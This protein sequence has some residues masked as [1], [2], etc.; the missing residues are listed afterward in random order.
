MTIKLLNK[1]EIKE[2]TIPETKEVMQE[3]YIY[4]LMLKNR[5]ELFSE[6]TLLS[7][8]KQQVKNKDS[9]VECFEDSISHVNQIFIGNGFYIEF[10]YDKDNTT[11][12]SLKS[13]ENPKP[14]AKDIND[15]LASK[16]KVISDLPKSESFNLRVHATNANL[17]ASREDLD[18]IFNTTGLTRQTIC[19]IKLGYDDFGYTFPI[20]KYSTDYYFNDLSLM[21]ISSYYNV[22]RNAVFDQINK[23]LKILDE[24]EDKLHL[25]ELYK[26]RNA[27]YEEY[28]S[29]CEELITKLREL[30]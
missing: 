29:S 28:S 8:Y 10:Y 26:K 27:L 16:N 30:E 17:L 22:S 15:A 9:Y 21:E 13:I 20:F 4:S 7:L 19:K 2:L 23:T 6:D 14:K 24:Y 1:S 25:Y 11:L 5:N 12:Y 3:N 18:F